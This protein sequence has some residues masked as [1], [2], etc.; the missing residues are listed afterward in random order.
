[1]VLVV[2]LVMVV[3]VLEQRVKTEL[4][5]YFLQSQLWAAVVVQLTGLVLM[6]KL[7]ALVVV[8]ALQE[9]DLQAVA[10]HQDK[11]IVAVMAQQTQ[12]VAV[13]VLAQLDCLGQVLMA[14][15]AVLELQVQ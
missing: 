13:E 11:E 2:R 12:A 10:V 3:L 8:E 6:Q 15:M 1:L 4:I 5:Q 7:V 14:V 9:L